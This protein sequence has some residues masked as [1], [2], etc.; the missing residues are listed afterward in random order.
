MNLSYEVFRVA[1]IAVFVLGVFGIVYVIGSA[2][3]RIASRL[4][5]RGLKRTRAIQ[6]N[7][8]WAAIEPLVR[9]LGVRVSGIPS[10]DQYKTL[11][12]Q[13]ALAGDFMG[14]T[15]DE[16]LALMVLG[17]IGG[18]VA[19]IV[20]GVMFN[21]GGVVILMMMPVGAALPY[22]QIS[23]YAQDRL[24][25]I[26]RGLPYVVDLMALC[27]G[28]GLDFPGAVRQ[29]IDKSSNPNDPIVEEFTLISQNLQLGRS[30]REAL[31]EFAKRAPVEAVKEFTGALI[32]AEERGNPVADV[33]QIQ[34]GASRMRRSVR[35]EE[36]AAKAGVQM[37]GPLML[38]FG[39]VMCLVGGPMFLAMKNF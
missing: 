11:D 27:M 13:I 30:R 12:D 35:A 34:A 4:G 10:E 2:P 5:L 9:W 37:I 1:G 24:K 36:N 28:A 15:A 32:Q 33:L 31:L 39:T 16:L 19:G 20:L 17:G 21:M 25:M 3:S 8:T 22:M 23:G 18:I 14:L 38:V 7:D 29:V 6:D 26:S